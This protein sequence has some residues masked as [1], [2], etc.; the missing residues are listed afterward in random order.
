MFTKIPSSRYLWP[1]IHYHKF[2]AKCIKKL[3]RNGVDVKTSL[4]PVSVFLREEVCAVSD[5]LASVSLFDSEKWMACLQY[6]NGWTNSDKEAEQRIR[7]LVKKLK[8]RPLTEPGDVDSTLLRSQI[9]DQYLRAMASARAQMAG[10]GAQEE[11]RTPRPS[12]Q[13]EYNHNSSRHRSLDH[14]QSTSVS[15]LSHDVQDIDEITLF[16]M[17]FVSD[18][19]DLHLHILDKMLHQQTECLRMLLPH[20][21]TIHAGLVGTTLLNPEGNGGQMVG[22]LTGLFTEMMPVL[23]PT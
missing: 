6:F 15:F 14:S 23:L 2:L 22:I 1:L 19:R 10:P 11:R 13:K 17:S 3:K 20:L 9:D 18:N 16:I 4:S 7:E 5:H 12:R 21:L 8:L